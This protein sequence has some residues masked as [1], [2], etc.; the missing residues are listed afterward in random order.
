MVFLQAHLLIF[1][2]IS[3]LSLLLSISG[4]LFKRVFF[5]NWNNKSY[6]ENG[7][8]GFILLGF[9]ALFLNFF[10]PLNLYINNLVL[11]FILTLG[12]KLNFFKQKI[13]K[14]L[15]KI[16]FTSLLA[17]I[18]IAYSNVN[19]PDAFLYH[20]PY[21][22]IIND[23]KI[24][25][26]LTNLHFR[27]GHISIFQ[28][29]SSLFV[30]SFFGI[31]GVL[32]PISLL[33]SFF[34]IYCF[35]KFKKDFQNVELRFFS[36][37][38]FII[39]IISLYSFNRYSGWGNDAQAHIYYFLVIIYFLNLRLDDNIDNFYKLLTT[40]L[41]CFF[42]KPFYLISFLI[43]L[44]FFLK[45]KYKLK[46]IKSKISIFL[47]LFSLFW[48]LKNVLVS[49]CFI[50]PVNSSCIKSTS[51][52]NETSTLK[53]SIESEAWSKDWNNNSN[54]SL[55]L[56]KYVKKFNWL[57]NW[58]NNHFK[59]LTEKIL[60]VLIFL[61]FNLILFFFSKCFKKKFKNEINT[62]L[63]YL[64]TINF[65]GCL[66]WFLKFPIFR[67]GASYLYAFLF[68]SIYILLINRIN[69]EKLFKLKFVF[70]LIIYLGF[71][72]IIIKNLI[73]IYK[74]EQISVY[75]L[76]YDKN[77]DGKVIK[78]YNSDG[79]FI[80]YRNEKGLCGYSRSPCRF[81]DTDIKKDIVLG[82]TIFK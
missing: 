56:K 27:F 52:Y 22:K 55:N 7:F 76:V 19:N 3:L 66:V 77:F 48:F 37:I 24:I 65:L 80:H 61:L 2:E 33:T 30:N 17:Y 12:L 57:K 73:R 28:Y 21:S 35:K 62:E 15:K 68:L 47:I 5:N 43:P 53:A 49:S 26:G 13:F 44:Y 82:Y 34:F 25:L 14:L 1:L 16:F 50:Y 81:I 23:D 4:F 78:F 31:K 36:Y 38:V 32:I 41:F 74:T 64:F 63:I 59:V 9:L 79:V 39:L 51:W 58:L 11:I 20:L 8:F 42:I 29:I 75:P 10:F 69:L 60:P 67:Y 18:F 71:F 54:K 6:E 40:S 45:S 72:G 70:L 46:I